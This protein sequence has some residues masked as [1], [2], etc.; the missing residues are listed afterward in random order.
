MT[1]TGGD[2]TGS[3]ERAAKMAFA[4]RRFVQSDEPRSGEEL[5]SS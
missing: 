3:V 1:H 2:E 5:V 4:S